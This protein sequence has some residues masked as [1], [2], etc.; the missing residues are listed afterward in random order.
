MMALIVLLAAVAIGLVLLGA[1]V[2]FWLGD[3]NDWD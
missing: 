2:W 3:V 1:V